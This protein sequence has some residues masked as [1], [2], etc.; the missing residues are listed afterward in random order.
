[1]PSAPTMTI[2]TA[3]DGSHVGISINNPDSPHH[4]RIK[5]YKV[6]D[7]AMSV[8]TIADNVSLGGEFTDWHVAY[9]TPYVYT[10]EAVDSGGAYAPS[11]S[12]SVSVT[13]G[14]LLIHAVTRHSSTSNRIGTPLS[15]VNLPPAGLTPIRETAGYILG[16]RNK[17]VVGAGDVVS[18]RYSTTV[19]IF[20]PQQAETL[21]LLQELYERKTTIC[22]RDQ[23]TNLLFAS[24]INLDP[25]W[26]DLVCDVELLFDEVDYDG[27]AS[28]IAVAS[29]DS[30]LQLET[31]FYILYEDMGRW[32]LEA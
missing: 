22:V 10:T 27:A 26:H 18:R 32:L 20:R 9:N 17:N 16:G 2:T 11:V 6:S 28:S 21:R 19:R 29:A 31:E 30:F 23:K 8:I 24:L 13:F 1:M 3:P 7:G 14:N 4:N 15:L 5:R 12:A 25:N